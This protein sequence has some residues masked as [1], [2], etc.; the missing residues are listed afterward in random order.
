MAYG[1]RLGIGRI[2]F[3]TRSYTASRYCHQHYSDNDHRIVVI[4]IE[5]LVTAQHQCSMRQLGIRGTQKST[6]GSTM[7]SR[8]VP[9]KNMPS[10]Y[11]FEKNPRKSTCIDFVWRAFWKIREKGCCTSQTSAMTIGN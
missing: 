2:A 3:E 10:T 4:S 5:T 11:P 6:R 9:S 7:D 1:E 8:K